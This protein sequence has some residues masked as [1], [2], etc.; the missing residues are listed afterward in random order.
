MKRYTSDDLRLA[1]AD[2]LAGRKNQVIVH[3]SLFALGRPVG[4]EPR[5]LTAT[6]LALLEQTLG[7]D[8]TI[9][10]PT[11]NFGFCNGVPFDIRNTPSEGMGSFAEFVRRHPLAKRTPH[12]MQSLSVLGTAAESICRPD[13]KCAYADEGAFGILRA[14]DATIL[15]LGV[16]FEAAS[17]IH[18]SEFAHN[19]PYRFRKPF[20]AEYIDELGQHHYRTYEMHARRE[21]PQPLLGLERLDTWLRASTGFRR[22]QVGSG[23]IRSVSARDLLDCVDAKLSDDPLALLSNREDVK[24]ALNT[25]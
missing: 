11:F 13:P 4:V 2:A 22:I 24:M 25:T 21:S 20:T 3:A 12:P 10:V 5:Q 18:F 7:E 17:I 1:L 23:E 6:L 19:V 16:G 15:L 8:A 14:L 9:A